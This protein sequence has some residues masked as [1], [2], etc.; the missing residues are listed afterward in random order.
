M[1]RGG[2]NFTSTPLC[3]SIA[4]KVILSIAYEVG[5]LYIC[6]S[7]AYEGIY[8]LLVKLY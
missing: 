3:V 4:C 2:I 5:M 8:I 6:V 7:T 1:T